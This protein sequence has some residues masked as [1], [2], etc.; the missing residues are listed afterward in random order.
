MKYLLLILMT[1]PAMTFAKTIDQFDYANYFKATSVSYEA[2]CPGDEDNNILCFLNGTSIT[3]TYSVSCSEKM[4]SFDYK[5]FDGP[6]GELDIVVAARRESSITTF[7]QPVCLGFKMVT[8]K[9]D[10]INVYTTDAPIHQLGEMKFEGLDLE[11][12]AFYY[13]Q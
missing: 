6:N 13:L 3:L 5:V 4:T 1:I 12:L 8:K 7:E 9:I 10:L 11:D 2:L